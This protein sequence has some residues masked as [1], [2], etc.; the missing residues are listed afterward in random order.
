MRGK[1]WI[2]GM[3]KSMV[4]VGEGEFYNDRRVVR[5]V[6]DHVPGGECVA[7]FIPIG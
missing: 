7:L 4:D 1:G 2:L 3:C 5:D 6:I